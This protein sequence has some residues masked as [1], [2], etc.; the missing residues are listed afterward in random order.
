MTEANL[1]SNTAVSQPS[2][3]IVEFDPR[4]A[5][6][7]T[8][9]MATAVAEATDRNVTEIPPL[10]EWVDCDA[11]EQLFSRQDPAHDLSLSFELEDCEV[12]VS[13]VGRI[14]VTPD[15]DYESA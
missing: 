5:D 6:S 9:R 1:Q 13:N 10:G 11:I 2:K 7:I 4:A 8:A 15:A 12:F 14:V 3:Q